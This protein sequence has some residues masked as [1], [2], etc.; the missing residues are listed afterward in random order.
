MLEIFKN[1]DDETKAKFIE[2]IKP[3]LITAGCMVVVF[4]A[5]FGAGKM[6]SGTM[7]GAAT[8]KRSLS[9]NYTTN[10]NPQTNI[11]TSVNTNKNSNASIPKAT[12]NPTADSCTTIKGSKSKM[13]HIPGGSFYDRTSAAQCF[14]TE[15]EAVAAGFTKSSR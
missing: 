5:G 10:T 8:S 1:F 6:H 11:G 15:E 9:A 2:T 14:T 13:Y 3:L 7:S 12:A 4:I